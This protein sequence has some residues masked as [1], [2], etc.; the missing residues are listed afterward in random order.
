MTI[1][2]AEISQILR[3]LAF[4]LEMDSNKEDKNLSFKNRAYLRAADQIENLPIHV[5]TIYKEKGLNGLL[6]IPLIGKAI[7]SKIE[8]YLNT[9]KIEYYEKLRIKYPIEIDDFLSLEG[10]GP[11]TLRGIIDAVPIRNLKDLE[12]LIKD[13]KLRT[14]PGFSQKKEINLLKK[15]ES[16]RIGK[17][18][19]LL[20]DLY[21]LVNQIEN[22]LVEQKK[23]TKIIVV[24]SFRRMK[25][26]VG[27]I[28]ILVVS[29]DP[30]KV[31]DDFTNMPHIKEVLSKGT[32]KAF[33][34]LNN[35]TDTDLLVVP[36]DSYGSASLYFTGSKEHGIVLRKLA[37]ARGYRLNEWGLFDNK[38]GQRLA[39]ESESG[40]YNLLGLEWIP[41]EMRENHGEIDM[42][43]KGSRTWI[44]KIQ[45]LI[46]Y[47]SLKGDLQVHSNNTDGQSS[48]EEMAYFART[49]FGL[50]YIAIS[51]H[52]KSLSI[53]RGLDEQQL[54]DQ[55]NKIN[56]INDRIKS[57]DFF[58]QENR[59]ISI[60]YPNKYLKE[61]NAKN[62]K[63]NLS[64]IDETFKILTAAEVNILR[65]GSLDISNNVLDKIDLVGA[66]IH[67]NF[68]LPEEI[69]TERLIRA[70][71]NPSVDIIFH[72]TGRIINKRDGYPVNMSKLLSIALETN[73]IL[74]IDAHYNRLDLKDEYIKMAIEKGIKLVIDSD[75][76]HPLHYTFLKFGIAQARRGWAERGDVLNT[77]SV[78]DLLRNLK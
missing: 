7:S 59:S 19:S 17:L 34:K 8:E 54:L 28:D 55:S 41:P 66:A 21:P 22:Y 1:S 31:I 65:D 4:L 53:A 24:G 67:S 2:N 48:I 12:D 10:I 38:T 71:R 44:N 26:T 60:D 9:G 68:A 51:D 58:A 40:I 43:K 76:H 62:L 30:V 35:G 49:I 77:L 29:K 37:Q 57:G 39:G 56:E 74:E 78:D 14:I 3:K 36:E 15:I 70:A 25:E 73:T 23:I 5:E 46:G 63:N 18:R 61:F 69:Q 6:Q 45:N 11:K 72:P 32:T 33:V 50:D 75:A 42:A 27:D 20:G 13:E 16:H 52:T 47:E 64:K